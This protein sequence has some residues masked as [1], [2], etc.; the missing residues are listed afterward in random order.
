MNQDLHANAIFNEIHPRLIASCC[1]M[2][3]V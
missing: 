3:R 1:E 2:K